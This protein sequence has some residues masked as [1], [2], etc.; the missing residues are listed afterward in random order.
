MEIISKSKSIFILFAMIGI[1]ILAGCQQEASTT[2]AEGEYETLTIR[3]QGN[4]GR[5]L[6][7]ELAEDLGYLDPIKLEWVNN[8]ISGPQS[9]QT[10]ATGDT[11]FGWAFNG[12]IVQLRA[13]GAPVKSVIG[14]YGSDEEEF[15]GYYVLEDSPI[16]EAKDFIGKTVGM[17]TLGAHAEFMLKEYLKQSGLTDKEIEQVTMVVVPPVNTEQALREKQIDVATLSGMSRELAVENGGIRPIF[18]DYELFGSFTAGSLMMTERF[19]QENPNTVRKLVEGTAKAIE[20]ARDTPREEVIARFEK[21][22][23][24]RDRQEDTEA[25]QYWKSAGVSEI[26]GYMQPESFQLWIDWLVKNGELEEGE[27]KVE[28]LFTNEFN[29]YKDEFED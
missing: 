18:K 2:Q 24:E 8:T 11:D 10:A 6:F 1:F 16:K 20:W 17:N 22:I 26:G 28:D 21:I 9:I 19:I 27:V 7:P 5:V 29:P 14:Y 15:Y 3:Y 13:N 12:A 23:E 25:L 4:A